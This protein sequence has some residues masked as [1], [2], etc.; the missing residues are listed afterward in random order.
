M[1]DLS[2]LAGMPLEVSVLF[3]DSGG[4]PDAA[5]GDAVAGT[6]QAGETR[7]ADLSPLKDMKLKVLLLD[8]TPVSDLS[9]L[10]GMALEHA[11]LSHT[12]ISD[13][14]PLK[15]MP[16]TQLSLIKTQ[17]SDL[18]PVEG[19]PLT[20]LTLAESPVSDLS[21]VKGMRLKELFCDFER[22]R[23]SQDPAL[24]HDPRADQRQTGGRIL[25]GSGRPVAPF[26]APP[27]L[28][29]GKPTKRGGR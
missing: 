20:T 7:V 12:S 9:P 1:S 29:R 21:P 25:E 10:R 16:M 23:D 8:G 2:P 6:V 14:S 27:R 19:M 11:G 22:E 3:P 17:V 24:A 26:L 28:R 5:E 15:G 13:I 18:S 4:G